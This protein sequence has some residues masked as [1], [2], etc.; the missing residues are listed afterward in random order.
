MVH[1]SENSK[2]SFKDC[3]TVSTMDRNPH[4]KTIPT[5]NIQTWNRKRQTTLTEDHGLWQAYYYVAGLN[6]QR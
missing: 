2:E 6:C 5:Q 1:K 3:C 4:C